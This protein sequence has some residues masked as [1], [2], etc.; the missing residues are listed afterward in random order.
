MLFRKDWQ[1]KACSDGKY[2]D[3]KYSN[4]DFFC[5][6]HSRNFLVEWLILIFLLD[7]LFSQSL[8]FWNSNFLYFDLP[9]IL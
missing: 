9:E 1:F 2:K 7:Q 3:K 4:P 5:T 6:G 8:L